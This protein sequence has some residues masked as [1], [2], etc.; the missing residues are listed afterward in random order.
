MQNFILA[1]I[2]PVAPLEEATQSLGGTAG[3]DLTA[4]FQVCGL[5]LAAIALVAYGMR[6]LIANGFKARAAQRSLQVID[7]MNL[8]GRRKLAVVRCY[9]RTFVLGMGEKEIA[10]IAELDPVIGADQPGVPPRK[11]DDEAFA[12]AL[13]KVQQSMPQEELMEKLLEARDRV[14]PSLAKKMKRTP[15]ATEEATPPSPKQ[16]VVQ[17]AP[18]QVPV[19]SPRAPQQAPATQA[20]AAAPEPN[21][22]RPKT[23]KKRIR[24]KVA[25]KTSATANTRRQDAEAAATAAFDMA[26]AKREARAKAAPQ[27]KPTAQPTQRAKP[28]VTGTESAEP[29]ILRMEGILG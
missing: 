8:G 6:K 28:A 10:P 13:E 3:P 26:T 9:D 5:L 16:V 1:L 4:Y 27:A 18:R 11:S 20:Q 21:K 23:Q 2:P 29:P 22:A 17:P 25:K 15:A 24:R 7:V 19:E 14:A 12:Q